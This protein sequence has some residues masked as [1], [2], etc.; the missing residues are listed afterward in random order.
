MR[1]NPEANS[2]V[3]FWPFFWVG[4]GCRGKNDLGDDLDSDVIR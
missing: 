3:P 2:S 1:L 4:G